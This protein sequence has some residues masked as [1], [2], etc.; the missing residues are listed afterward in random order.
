MYETVS[1][2][3]LESY[4]ARG[5]FVASF[6]YALFE[7][8]HKGP[9]RDIYEWG[10]GPGRVLRHL[11]SFITEPTVQLY[12]SDYEERSIAWA[13]K[14]LPGINFCINDLTPPLPFADQSFDI[15]Y[16][17]SVFTHLS[18][19]MHGVWLD[20]L[21]RVLREHGTLVMT[22][23]GDSFRHK[24]LGQE[25]AEYDSGKL[26]V[27]SSSLEGARTYTA[28]QSPIFMRNTLLS[29]LDVKVHLESPDSRLMGGQ[30]VWVVGR[31]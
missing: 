15:V 16:C 12:G 1:A 7:E 31:P 23:H 11:P 20:E 21:L 27:R 22:T 4:I 28:F 18:Q 29:G 24:L 30:D 8:H 25:I 19:H 10:C 5:Q 2:V 26:V 13:S 9:I 14:S 17:T 6:L 3:S